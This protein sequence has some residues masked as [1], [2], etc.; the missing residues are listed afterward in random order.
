MRMGRPFHC[1]ARIALMAASLLAGGIASAGAA[2]V[3]VVKHQ[4]VDRIAALFRPSSLPVG[5]APLVIALH[6]LGQS[7]ESL[8]D[9]LHLDAA[10]ERER[11]VVVY[12]EAIERKWSYGKPIEGPMPRVNGKIVDDVGFISRVIDGLIEMK[13]ADPTHVY[14]TGM[15]RG[16]LMTYALICALADRFAAAAPLITGM[17]DHQREHCRPSRP[18]PIMVVAGTNDEA[19]WYDG[20][21]T[22]SGRLLSIPETLEFWR[23]RNGCSKE[24][25][26]SL[27][28]RDSSDPTRVRML[29]WTR[30]RDH[31]RLRLYRVNDGGH[32]LPSFSPS[33]EQTTKLFGLRNHDI[34]TADEF[35]SFAKTIESLRHH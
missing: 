34:E 8:H 26:T 23:Q 21:I 35:W 14:V 29:E 10:A 15:S 25:A 9:W 27:P 16:G 33:D 22:R 19:Q 11:F 32:Q 1:F 30:C 3:L 12:P 28:H 5:P 6:G 13:V 18:I 4:G 17:T 31:A 24:T 7:I 20:Q 2:P